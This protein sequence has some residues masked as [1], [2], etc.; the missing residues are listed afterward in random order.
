MVAFA[1]CR[2][3]RKPLGSCRQ[4]E[5][6]GV[7]RG[8]HEDLRQAVEQAA[9]PRRGAGVSDDFHGDVGIQ[10]AGADTV[11]DAHGDDV[12]ARVDEIS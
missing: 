2:R 10:A 1:L 8:L 4:L 6:P 12:V 9:R 3:R 7:A 11:V 5:F